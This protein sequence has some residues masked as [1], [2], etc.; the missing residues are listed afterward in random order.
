MHMIMYYIHTYLHTFSLETANANQRHML[1]RSNYALS[2][3]ITL[4]RR[5]YYV[6]PFLLRWH[7]VNPALTTLSLCL[8]HVL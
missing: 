8:Y 6:K 3:S 7:H 5:W 2:V 4:L 1:S